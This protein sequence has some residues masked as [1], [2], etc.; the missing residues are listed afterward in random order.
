MAIGLEDPLNLY[1]WKWLEREH[2]L[3]KN[4]SA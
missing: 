1:G 4:L 2:M 3:S